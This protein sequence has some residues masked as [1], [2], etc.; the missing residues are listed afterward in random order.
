MMIMIMNMQIYFQY[1][2][3]ISTQ[4]H[5]ANKNIG[6]PVKNKTDREIQAPAK[7]NP[8]GMLNFRESYTSD[9]VQEDSN[10]KHTTLS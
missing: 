5:K 1:S 4:K 6:K 3:T 2:H 10:S 7:V 9:M 8:E